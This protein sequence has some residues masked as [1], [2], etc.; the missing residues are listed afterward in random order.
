MEKKEIKITRGRE[1]KEDDSEKEI[2]IER[3][4]KKVV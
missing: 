3:R 2:K 1:I 4:E